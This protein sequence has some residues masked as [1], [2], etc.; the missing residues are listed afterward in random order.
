M[1]G[2]VLNGLMTNKCVTPFF[3]QWKR[4]LGVRTDKDSVGERGY[5]RSW[6]Q[7]F[8]ARTVATVYRVSETESTLTDVAYRQSQTETQ[9]ITT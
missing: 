8:P 1:A 4:M 2:Y 3:E 6:N 7:K 9:L 5:W